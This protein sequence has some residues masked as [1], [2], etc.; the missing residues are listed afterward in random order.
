[1]SMVADSVLT[2][3]WVCCVFFCFYLCLFVFF[4]N[5]TATTEIYTL[6]LHDALPIYIESGEIKEQ[7]V[8]FGQIPRITEGGTFVVNGVERIIVSQIVR[9]PGIFFLPNSSVP[10]T[11][12]IGRAHV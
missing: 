5:D 8:Y 4:F 3:C 9:S 7:D 2:V 10:G 12:Q 6:S 1:M 11:Y